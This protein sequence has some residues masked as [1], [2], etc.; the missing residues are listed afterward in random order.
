MPDYKVFGRLFRSDLEFPELA[1]APPGALPPGLT[2]R[3]RGPEGVPAIPL[4]SPIGETTVGKNAKVRL[5]RVG[6]EFLL[7]ISDTGTFRISEVEISWWPGP[8]GIS[9]AARV[10][11]KGRA[12]P[13]ALH[14]EGTLCLHAG[15]VAA[16]GKAIAFAGPK[17]AGKSTL[18]AALVSVG[19]EFVTDDVLAASGSP[20]AKA[21]SGFGSFR[22]WQDS[23]S[24]VSLDPSYRQPGLGGKLN[25]RSAPSEGSAMDGALPLAAVYFLRPT[26]PAIPLESARRLLPESTATIALVGSVKNGEIL[27]GGEQA[28]LFDLASELARTVPCY[29]LPVPRALE[30]L[31]RLARTIL[32]WHTEPGGDRGNPSVGP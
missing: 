6:D 12:V 27:G 4:E 11:I 10:D 29:E 31:P 22:L 16:D 25:V 15:A 26:D 2:L 3:I 24:L 18:T 5:F 14:L 8:E 21:F 30:L 9:E 23:A 7:Q 32:G 17:R 13:L 20:S 19:A 28:R 1:T